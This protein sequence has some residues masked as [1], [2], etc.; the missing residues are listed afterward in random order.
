MDE[1]EVPFR[2]TFARLVGF[3]HLRNV[4]GVCV[5]MNLRYLSASGSFLTARSGGAACAND[6]G[7]HWAVVDLRPYASSKIAKVKVQ[8]QTQASDGSWNVAGAQTVS[9]AEARS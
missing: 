6:N 8:L 7:Y 1:R 3:L 2:R 4:A 9:I 5:R